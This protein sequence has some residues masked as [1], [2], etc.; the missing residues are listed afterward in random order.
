MRC[1]LCVHSWRIIL[2]LSGHIDAMAN[3]L[4]EQAPSLTLEEYK[5]LRG[6]IDYQVKDNRD[7]ERYALIGT[8]IVYSWLASIDAPTLLVIPAWFFPPLLAIIGARR[9]HSISNRINQIAEYIRGIEAEV[10]GSTSPIRGWETMVQ[11]A[12]ETK[13]A[14]GLGRSRR[15]FWWLLIT[16]TVTA[17]V[18]GFLCQLRL[19]PAG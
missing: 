15:V 17:S 2:G 5:S 18:F 4:S 7:L 10:Y 16:F 3:P 9:A 11:S 1:E 6:Q 8:G 12:K 19:L 13:S 14:P